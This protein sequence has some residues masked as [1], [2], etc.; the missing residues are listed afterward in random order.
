MKQTSYGQDGNNTQI[1]QIFIL[2]TSSPGSTHSRS[3]LGKSPGFLWAAS[4][5]SRS[6][7]QSAVIAD[8]RFSR[9][10]Y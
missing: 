9:E 4:T 5:S 1:P 3:M 8:L 6:Y 10:R 7:M 2:R